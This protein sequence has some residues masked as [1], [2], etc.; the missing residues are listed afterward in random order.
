MYSPPR[1]RRRSIWLLAILS[2]AVVVVVLV[3]SFRSE[4]RLLAGYIDTA[5]ESSAGAAAAAVEFLDLA[6]R[7]GEVD[8]QEFTT[9][10]A[11]IRS[12]AGAA[13][14]LL[15]G[16]EAP[17]DA[18]G[19]HAR[20]QLALS[21][22]LLGLELMEGATLAAADDPADAIAADLID[23]AV[24]E[25]AVGD[26]AYEAAVDELLALEERTDV[27]IPTYPVVVFAP[28]QGAA[29]L[30]ETARTA[31]GL[32]QRRDLAV[33]AVGFEPRLLSETE[34]GVGILP[35]ID[36]LIVNVTVTNLGNEAAAAIPVQVLLSSDRTGT[37][38]SETVTIERLQPTEATSLEFV[39]E[40]LPGVN[41]ELVVNAGPVT[42][43]SDIDNNLV[44]VPFIVNQQG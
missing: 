38:A 21:S 28:G 32:S 41:Y 6:G 17:Q 16:A 4:R 18:V 40:V 7:L 8:R 24:V 19:A 3:T 23:R 11:R 12:M 36:R 9:T 44:V 15:E 13:D 33:S 30:L 31:P 43:E 26:R 35:F 2:V 39:F 22:W 37:S 29:G 34:A 1:R 14:V 25:L 20:L 42:G 10:M 5:Q 27:T